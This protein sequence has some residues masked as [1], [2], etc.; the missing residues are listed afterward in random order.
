[1][2]EFCRRNGHGYIRMNKDPFLAN[3]FTKDLPTERAA[4]LCFSFKVLLH[5][6]IL[7]F[8]FDKMC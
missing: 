1:M 4:L 2:K 3:V 8:G 6:T 7:A 5:K